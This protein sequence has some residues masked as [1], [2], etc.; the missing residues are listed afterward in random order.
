VSGSVDVDE[1]VILQPL[2]GGL[3]L[4]DNFHGH[5]VVTHLCHKGDVSQ[6]SEHIVY[7]LLAL[8]VSAQV[9]KVITGVLSW[10]SHIMCHFGMYLSL[11]DGLSSAHGAKDFWIVS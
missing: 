11:V 4:T 7:L 10:G 9:P 5:A 6:V 3:E 1:Q 2:D 8:E